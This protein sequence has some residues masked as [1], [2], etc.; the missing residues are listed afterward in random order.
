IR[1]TLAVS[2][3]SAFAAAQTSTTPKLDATCADVVIFMAR[4]NNAPYHD[5]RTTPFIDATCSKLTAEGKSCDYIDI[6]FDVTLGGDYCAQITEGAANGIKQVTAFNQKCPCSHIIVNGYSEG[7]NVAGDVLGGPGGCS[8]VSTGI[9][10]TSSAGK[11]IA[12]ALLW[13]DVRHTE[14][15]PYNVLDGASKGPYPRAG[16]DL[17]NLNRYSSI[18]RSYCAAGDPV[19]AGGKTVADHLN[20][21]ELYTDD[22]SSWVVAKV[23][24]AA[25]LCGASSSS[26]SVAA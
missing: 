22:A 24:A 12:A 14:N 21:F 15:Q 25:P 13:G 3:L 2:A 20:Y 17:A 10:N 6:Q 8:F 1:K 16:A 19:C 4:G 26:S 9:D 18:L 11:A 23:D 5:D 7:A